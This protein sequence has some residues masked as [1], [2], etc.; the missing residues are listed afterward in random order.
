LQKALLT[1]KTFVSVSWEI[2]KIL[3]QMCYLTKYLVQNPKLIFDLYEF[4]AVLS[5]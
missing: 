2:K 3:R 1:I 4:L 5:M